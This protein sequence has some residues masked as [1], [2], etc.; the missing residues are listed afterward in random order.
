MDRIKQMLKKFYANKKLFVVVCVICL[1][2]LTIGVSYSAFFS[3]KTNSVNQVV[4]TGSLNVTYSGNNSVIAYDYIEPLTDEEG[5]AQ[6]ANRIVT[7][8]NTSALDSKYTVTIG[9]DMTSFLARA[10]YNANDELT[11]IEYAR[12]ALYEYD[13]TNSTSTLISGP[14]SIAEL[15]IYSIDNSDSRYNKYSLLIDTVGSTTSGN[16]TKTYQIKIWL[17][18][19]ATAAA[20]D[21][22]FYFNTEVIAR[23][24]GDTMRY[25]INGIL[26]NET[27]TAITGATI[28]LHN[29]SIV[30]TTTTGGAFTLENVP[31][32]TYN[33]DITASN[34]RYQANLTVSEG[35]E[36]AVHTLDS[37]F[38]PP[39]NS[40][41]YN[42]SYL[43]KTTPYKI[44]DANSIGDITSM[45]SLTG[46]YWLY[47]TYELMGGYESNIDTLVI[48][49][50]NTNY[51]NLKVINNM[52]FDG[53]NEVYNN[54]YSPA[55]YWNAGFPNHD[56]AYTY[57]YPLGQKVLASDYWDYFDGVTQNI[58][59]T[60]GSPTTYTTLA[61]LQSN[62]ANFSTNPFY[63]KTTTEHQVCLYYNNH[64]F[65]MSNNYWEG[66]IGVNDSAAGIATKNKLQ[67]EMESALGTSADSCASY[68]AN[69]YCYFGGFCCHANS[70]GRVHCNQNVSHAGC[71]VYTDGPADCIVG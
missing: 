22:Y 60:S 64:E 51:L 54:L 29:G 42:V 59:W 55:L 18:D 43:Y 63:I 5:M 68:D 49:I 12:L 57:S 9:Y 17:S 45:I 30:T 48:V 38:N 24:Q 61:Q 14:I 21:T 34:V 23:P 56:V 52:Y 66:T 4:S 7:V 41:I 67:S 16:A 69:A 47:P 10:D 53:T 35:T 13:T 15:P 28:N 27:G 62:Y 50:G 2:S 20:T 19:D 58:T 36:K 11:P 8:Q 1:S 3:V 31:V 26:Q 33:L 40:S 32:G 65:C 37:Q 6:T 39:N 46:N 44:I 71:E 70:S 25:T